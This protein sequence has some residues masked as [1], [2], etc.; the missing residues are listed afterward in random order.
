M[1]GI[2]IISTAL[3]G[4]L[5]WFILLSAFSLLSACGGGG[6]GED[7]TDPRTI[8][9]QAPVITINGEATINLIQ[10]DEYIDLGAIGQD[11]VDGEITITIDGTVDTSIVGTYVITY[12]ATDASGNTISITRTIHVLEPDITPPVISLIGLAT[13]SINEGGFYVEYGATATDERDGTLEVSISGAVNSN[14]PGTYVVNYFAQD[15]AGNSASI[16]RTVLVFDIT[17]PAIILNGAAEISIN[18]DTLYSELGATAVDAVNGPVNV[19]V[20]GNVNIATPG[21]YTVNYSAVDASGNRA[22]SN[23]TVIVLDVTAPIITLTGNNPHIQNE[24]SQYIEPGYSANDNSGE[25]VTVNV[26]GSVTTSTP[27][28]YTLTYVAADSAGNQSSVNRIVN[29]LDVTAPV[30]TLIGD[31]PVIQNEDLNYNEPGY[32]ATDNGDENV[33]VVVTGEVNTAT[34]GNYSLTYS[35]TDIAGNTTSVTRTINVLDVT[36]PVITLNGSNPINQNEDGAYTELGATAQDNSDDETQVTISGTVD[37]TTPGSYVVTY[38]SID[39]AGNAASITR[40]VNVLDVTPPVI[41]LN[42]GAN[43]TVS[44]ES[45]Y[46]D[47]G[48]SATD[49]LD[50]IVLVSISGSVNTSTIGVYELTYTA[51]DN[52]GNSSSVIRTVNIVDVIAPVVT[53]NGDAIMN[54]PFASSYSDLGAL[55]T[56]DVDEAVSVNMT[57]SVDTS[58]IGGYEITYTATDSAGNTTSVIRTVNVVDVTAPVIDLMGE[59]NITIVQGLDYFDPVT[60]SD[61]VDGV[62]TVAIG[63]DLDTGTVGTYTRSYMATDA[64]GNQTSATRTITVREFLAFITTWKTDNEGASED[65][66]IKITTVISGQNYTVDWGD[67]SQDTGVTDEI[68]HTYASAGIYT[69]SIIGDFKNIQFD[70]SDSDRKKLLTIEQWGEIK[71][72]TMER[73]F[74]LCENLVLNASDAPDLAN[75][76]SMYLMF[77][78]ASAFYGDVSQWDVSSVTNMGSMFRGASTFNGDL[79]QWGVSAVTNMSHMFRSASTFNGD[80]SQWDVSSVTDMDNMFESA[81]AFNSDISQWDVSLVTSMNTM[82]RNAAAFNS[83]LN[84]WDVSSVTNMQYMFEKALVFNS[85]LSQ[86]DVSSVTNMRSMFSCHGEL[87]TFNGDVSQWDVSAV[88]DMY[89]MFYYAKAFNGDLSQWNVFS[90]TDMSWMFSNAITFNSDI[91]LWDV[92]SVTDASY[93]FYYADIFNSDVSQ[94]DVSAITDMRNMF[95]NAKVFNSDISQW[96]VSA[97][98]NMRFMFDNTEVFNSDI[99]QWNVSAVTNMYGMFRYSDAFNGDISQ[100]DVSAVTDMSNTFRDASAFNGDI[101]LWDVSAV[102]DMSY[103][104]TCTFNTC[105]FNRDISQWDVSAVTDM[106]NMFSC[107]YSTCAFNGDISQWNTALVTN[108]SKMFTCFDSACAFNGNISQWDVAAVTDM[109]R[110]FEGITLS[111]ENYDALL[112]GWG[113]QSLQSGVI[114]DGGDSQYSSSAQSSRDALVNSYGWTVTDGG[115]QTP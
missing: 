98:T 80:L 70:D 3:T 6:G 26:S 84:Q 86:W 109:A 47:L 74:Y 110:M 24:N 93:M 76:T 20:T 42:G 78:G 28:S 79:S 41:T 54:V 101:S 91:N 72:S 108:M 27:G 11:L 40:T 9:N 73:A 38:S 53:L 89:Q 29:V 49:N 15:Q 111:T 34:P 63:G 36:A 14:V 58:K 112:Q 94:W 7:N 85:D 88:T 99:S 37:S 64:S 39:S 71:W 96:D 61:D 51:T 50:E 102:T 106:D 46:V 97:V 83:D 10:G 16:E 92:S 31:N 67:G 43:Q 103:M 30:I 68:A 1:N 60:A 107:S 66:Q 22:N 44:F 56:D 55:A 18:E 13:L 32:S 57:G 82:F 45:I 90:V 113:S 69:V 12:T 8:D 35:A 25:S 87:C 17:A 33:S 75:V 4:H 21:T 59:S 104:F 5:K 48:V 23:R 65:N 105:A 114:F 100:W 62:I 81:L 2:N 19:V 52:A 95:S 115:L 77:Y